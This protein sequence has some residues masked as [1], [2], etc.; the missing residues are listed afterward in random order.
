MLQENID[1]CFF[2]ASKVEIRRISTFPFLL[3]R[4]GRELWFSFG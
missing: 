4:I 1:L 2:N 3:G